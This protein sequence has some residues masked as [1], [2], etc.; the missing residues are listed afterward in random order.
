MKCKQIRGKSWLIIIIWRNICLLTI[1][2]CETPSRTSGKSWKSA[3]HN[4]SF[5]LV[6]KGRFSRLPLASRGGWCQTSPAEGGNAVYD[7][8]WRHVTSSWRHVMSWCVTLL[9]LKSSQPPNKSREGLPYLPSITRAKP[10][11]WKADKT[12]S[13]LDSSL[14][15]L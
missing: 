10:E 5:G 9:A 13:S 4:S 15:R 12:F 3:F 14:N 8:T 2:V 7:V 6:V 1:K 11:G